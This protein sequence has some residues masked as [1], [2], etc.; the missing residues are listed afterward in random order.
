VLTSTKPLR[1]HPGL[2]PW[3]PLRQTLRTLVEQSGYRCFKLGYEPWGFSLPSDLAKLRVSPEAI[4]IVLDVGANVGSWALD[5]HNAFVNATIHA[6]EPIPE[7][8]ERLAQNT[9][10]LPRIHLWP[11]G[12][13]D[14]T[15][16]AVMQVYDN[17]E[18]NSLETKASP[19]GRPVRT[20]AI[21]CTTIDR[22]VTEHQIER[23]DL[24]KLDVEGHEMKAL[25]G[26]RG[27]LEAGKVEFLLLETKGVLASTI[28]GPGVA[29]EALSSLLN[30]LGYRLLV[31]YTDFINPACPALPSDGETIRESRTQITL[32]PPYTNFNALFGRDQRGI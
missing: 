21:S 14:Q 28:S 18:V 12:V 23:V 11:S 9:R 10:A 6:F 31:L 26:A 19:F 25:E 17:C 5:I 13:S 4:R 8:F 3:K 29:L 24:I 16:T 30:P 27:L 22:F 20:L 2:R 7:I 15:G 32:K 1:C